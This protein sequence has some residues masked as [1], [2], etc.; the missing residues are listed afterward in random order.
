M[1][2]HTH[3]TQ[4]SLLISWLCSADH[5]SWCLYQNCSDLRWKSIS[6]GS[7]IY[8]RNETKRE[9]TVFGLGAANA[10]PSLP[11]KCDSHGAC[12]HTRSQI[13]EF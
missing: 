9:A 4:Q 1:H 6:H 11:D 2:T 13:S 3:E 10:C 12:K 7:L 8:C 5:E